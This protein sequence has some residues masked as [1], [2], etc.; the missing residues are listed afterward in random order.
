MLPG[1]RLEKSVVSG[2]VMGHEYVV[3]QDHME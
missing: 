3:G 2:N 1:V